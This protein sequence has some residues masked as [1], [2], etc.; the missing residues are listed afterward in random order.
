MAN[1]SLKSFESAVML[2]L[3]FSFLI[4]CY[5]LASSHLIQPLALFR[6]FV[7]T[8]F[9]FA[10]SADEDLLMY[11]CFFHPIFTYFCLPS[12]LF[13]YFLVLFCSC[14]SWVTKCFP[15]KYEFSHIS[16][17]AG[18]AVNF[19]I[20]NVISCERNKISTFSRQ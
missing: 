13:T 20:C 7:C 19:T 14:V 12:F 6:I 8:H 17:V 4:C 15:L 5:F 3:L 10:A 11:L 16:C 9:V 2:M 1:M 18:C